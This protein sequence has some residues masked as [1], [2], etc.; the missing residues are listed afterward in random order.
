MV[1]KSK[2][3]IKA[4]IE[5]ARYALSN[6]QSINRQVDAKIGGI[7]AVLG[8]FLGFIYAKGG[9]MLAVQELLKRSG[10]LYWATMICLIA[11]VISLVLT[12]L[13]AALTIT[14]HSSGDVIWAKQKWWILFPLTSKQNSE[15]HIRAEIKRRM[16][17][18]N[19]FDEKEM[20]EELA[21]QLAICGGIM[22]KKMDRFNWTLWTSVICG[23]SAISLSVLLV[24]LSC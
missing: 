2:E 9:F 4:C 13:F 21:E 7:T 17:D 16:L 14:A 20:A 11:V 3:D 1:L 6:V 12:F 15:T 10:I 18:E 8:V 24:I 22:T 5:Y 19:V 23:L